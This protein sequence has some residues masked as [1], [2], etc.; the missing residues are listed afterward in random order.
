MATTQF[1]VRRAVFALGVAALITA[2]PAVAFASAP[3]VV[4]DPGDCESSIEPGNASLNC[5]PAVIPNVGAPSEMEV[6]DT[7]PGLGS[8][9]SPEHS[10]RR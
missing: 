1:T 10:G 9:A 5:S 3:R 4:A 6:N 2:A 8:P 7:S